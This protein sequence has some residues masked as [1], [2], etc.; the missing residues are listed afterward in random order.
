MIQIICDRC[1]QIAD[2]PSR[3]L[4]LV[5]SE[6]NGGD[7]D[8]ECLANNMCPNCIAAIRDWLKDSDAFAMRVAM[9]AIA[10]TINAIDGQQGVPL[11]AQVVD[12][13]GISRAAIA[14]ARAALAMLRHDVTEEK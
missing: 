10:Q 2:G 3:E 1:E 9:D 5:H 12:Y 7:G 11:V 8:M 13:A 14:K 6:D 4:S